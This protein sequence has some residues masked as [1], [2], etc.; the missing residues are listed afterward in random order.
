M[1]RK[2]VGKQRHM[3]GTMKQRYWKLHAGKKQVENKD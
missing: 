2:A 3:L 1:L